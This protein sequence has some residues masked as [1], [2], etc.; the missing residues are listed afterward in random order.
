MSAKLRIHSLFIHHFK[1]T[2]KWKSTD[3]AQRWLTSQST[4][5]LLTLSCCISAMAFPYFEFGR[6]HC[7]SEVIPSHTLHVYQSP[8]IFIFIQLLFIPSLNLTKIN[9]LTKGTW[10]NLFLLLLFYF[11]LYVFVVV[12]FTNRRCVHEGNT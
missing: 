8:T 12:F 5:I 2:F 3:P 9:C 4:D 1:V 6:F 11:C 10:Q 7:Q